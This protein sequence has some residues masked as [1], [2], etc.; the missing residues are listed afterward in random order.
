MLRLGLRVYTTHQ[1]GCF[2]EVNDYGQSQ[3]QGRGIRV[4]VCFRVL[5]LGLGF[6]DFR[7]LRWL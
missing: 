5:G 1:Q 7:S 4:V 6:L 3:S 2:Y